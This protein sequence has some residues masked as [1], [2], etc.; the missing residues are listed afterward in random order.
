MKV[1]KGQVNKERALSEKRRQERVLITWGIVILSLIILLFLLFTFW[2]KESEYTDFAKCL[3]KEGAI[4]YGTDWC[5]HCQMQKR[6]FGVA[7]KEVNFVNC[8]YSTSC[9]VAGI[10]GYPTWRFND[11]SEIAG[12]AALEQLAEKTGCR[13]P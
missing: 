11:G 13:L 4:M 12:S 5:T 1:S 2:P 10:E 9:D 6:L 7:F 3:A 8:D